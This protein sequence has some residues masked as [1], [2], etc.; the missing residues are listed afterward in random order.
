[1]N[2]PARTLPAPGIYPGMPFDEYLAIPAASASALKTV[3]VCPAKLGVEREQSAAMRLG[4]LTHCALLEPGEMVRRYALTDLGR[5]GTK[6]WAAEEEAAGGREL[7]KRDEWDAAI[8]MCDSVRRHP[9]A[10]A[11]LEGAATERTLIWIDMETGVRCKAR[12][13]ALS[14]LGGPIDI[15]TAADASPHGWRKSA[16]RLMYHIQAA[17]YLAGCRAL[18][19]PAEC[20]PFIV[21]ESA[22]PFIVE[23]Y[24]LSARTVSE[25]ERQRQ[26]LLLR[27]QKYASAHPSERPG[28]TGNQFTEIEFSEFT[29]SRSFAETTEEY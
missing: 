9:V 21:I 20:M 12:L 28:Y 27:W 6:A 11:L 8:A 24:P 14:P 7:V 3:A 4:S 16:E 18:G 13:D 5:S 1:M 10:R 2:A 22:P 15:K 25:G 26:E 29:L 23:V 19:L 17:H